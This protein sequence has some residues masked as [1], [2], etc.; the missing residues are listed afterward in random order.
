MLFL[1]KCVQNLFHFIL[2][3]PICRCIV[4]AF[5]HFIQRRDELIICIGRLNY[6]NHRRF[7]SQYLKVD[8]NIG[9]PYLGTLKSSTEARVKNARYFL[10]ISPPL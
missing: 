2:V 6:S 5:H 3:T 10:I 4:S 7:A 8:C 1:F 9:M